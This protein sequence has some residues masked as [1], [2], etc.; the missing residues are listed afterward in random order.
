[1]GPVFPLEMEL[2]ADGT[3]LMKNLHILRKSS[4]YR[5]QITIL[6]HDMLPIIGQR[7][8]SSGKNFE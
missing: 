2:K 6:F 8:L 3:D 4:S 1:M 5:Q 7:I